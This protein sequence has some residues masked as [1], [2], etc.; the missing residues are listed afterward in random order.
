MQSLF[1]KGLPFRTG[2]LACIFSRGNSSPWVCASSLIVNTRH[3]D[4]FHDAKGRGIFAVALGED[5][6]NFKIG[7]CKVNH[8]G[9][10][11]R[12]ISSA[13]VVFVDYPA[14]GY[15]GMVFAVAKVEVAATDDFA[16]ERDYK[17]KVF[18]LF[19]GALP[20]VIAAADKIAGFFKG[21]VGQ[22]EHHCNFLVAGVFV[23]LSLVTQADWTKHQVFCF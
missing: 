1:F 2:Y 12:G 5:A 13:P 11:L 8:G 4:F 21:L 22:P 15:V 6:V 14:K 9:A 17:L 10:C 16:I 19:K 7:K 18:Y 23:N 3:A 20:F